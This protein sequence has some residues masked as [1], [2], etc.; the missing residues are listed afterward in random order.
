MQF[1]WP[2]MLLIAKKYSSE[3]A[4]PVDQSRNTSQVVSPR[5]LSGHLQEL[6]IVFIHIDKTSP[7]S[8][9]RHLYRYATYV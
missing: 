4:L 8:G 1:N 3:T 6:I 7:Y 9:I 5:I 2:E